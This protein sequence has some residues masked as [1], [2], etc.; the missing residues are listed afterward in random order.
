M[1]PVALV[2]GVATVVGGAY[3]ASFMLT[4][5]TPHHFAHMD[6]PLWTDK[7]VTVD[8]DAQS[9]ER[10]PAMVAA[11][12]IPAQG[13]LGVET[14]FAANAATAPDGTRDPDRSTAAMGT[15]TLPAEVA[16]SGE[17]GMALDT[18]H[19]DWC[20]A[21]YRSYRVEDNTYQPFDAAGRRACQSPY[22]DTQTP[23]ATATNVGDQGLVAQAE[24]VSAEAVEPQVMA[25]AGNVDAGWCFAQYRSYR[26]EDNSY[27]PFDGGPRRQCVPRSGSY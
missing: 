18:A 23:V 9:L 1:L 15:D 21:R 6:A 11:A 4:D 7:P 20:F 5:Y 26:A 17:G 3:A 12:D 2:M 8:R 24:P 25:D 19:V 22:D 16:S 13:P 10:L 27:Q 14:V